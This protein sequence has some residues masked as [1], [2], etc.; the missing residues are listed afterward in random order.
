MKR[1]T[2][3]PSHTQPHILMFSVDLL[4]RQQRQNLTPVRFTWFQDT[5]MQ[6]H[7]LKSIAHGPRNLTSNTNQEMCVPCNLACTGEAGTPE[8][9]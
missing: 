1:L 3:L 5:L 6:L 8:R 7:V 9:L 4:V 2:F